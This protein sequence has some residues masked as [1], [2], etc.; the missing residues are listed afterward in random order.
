MVLYTEQEGF[1]QSTPRHEDVCI[2]RL[3]CE[4]DRFRPEGYSGKILRRWAFLYCYLYDVDEDENRYQPW[5]ACRFCGIQPTGEDFHKPMDIYPWIFIG[6][7]PGCV[8]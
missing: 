5:D 7:C 8:H 2:P 4:I 3:Q 6:K 1:P